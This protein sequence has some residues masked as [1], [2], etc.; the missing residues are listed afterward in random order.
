[1]G[2]GNGGDIIVNAANVD[3]LNGGNITASTFENGKAGDVT[4]N[5]TKQVTLSGSDPKFS[6]WKARL[7]QIGRMLGKWHNEITLI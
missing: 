2:D 7:P 6:Q 4:V 3:V 1:M 5:A